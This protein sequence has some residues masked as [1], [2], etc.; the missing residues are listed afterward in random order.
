MQAVLDRGHGCLCHRGVGGKLVIA[1]LVFMV[2]PIQ[3][4]KV[5]TGVVCS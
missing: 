4:S 5:Q 2:V 3:H 1:V